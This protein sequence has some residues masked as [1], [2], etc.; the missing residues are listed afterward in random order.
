MFKEKL[1]ILKSKFIKQSEGNNKRKIENLVVFLI[2]LI[3]TVI[4]INT[5]WG[6]KNEETKQ[7]ENNSYKQLAQSIDN[8]SN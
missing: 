1:E 2:L 8:S 6:D 7:E 3:I 4:A 5:I